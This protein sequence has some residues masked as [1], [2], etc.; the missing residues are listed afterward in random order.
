MHVE[1]VIG[2]VRSTRTDGLDHHR[3]LGNAPGGCERHHPAR[4]DRPLVTFLDVLQ[5]ASG[6]EH[7][8]AQESADHDQRAAQPAD[9]RQQRYEGRAGGEGQH[10][11]ALERAE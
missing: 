10:R 3:Q 6:E 4:R 7:P 5:I 1:E 2:L 11:H 8:Q 9:D